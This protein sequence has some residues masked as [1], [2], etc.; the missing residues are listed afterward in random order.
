[1]LLKSL[2]I[3]HGKTF[4]GIRYYHKLLHKRVR[5]MLEG[6]EHGEGLFSPGLSI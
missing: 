1:M 5:K 3:A 4:E 6:C 2:Q